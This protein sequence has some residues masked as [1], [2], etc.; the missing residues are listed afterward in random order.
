MLDPLPI[1]EEDVVELKCAAC[2]LFYDDENE[3][4]AIE[5]HG[6]CIDCTERING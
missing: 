5:E 4:E 2:G 1:G 6:T 3:L